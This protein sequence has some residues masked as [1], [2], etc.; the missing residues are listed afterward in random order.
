M[1]DG[2]GDLN[3]DFKDRTV[4]V[5]GASRGLGAAAARAFAAA[6]A[7][8]FASARN[9]D[10]LAELAKQAAAAGGDIRPLPASVTSTEEVEA[11]AAAIAED[12]GGIDILVANAGISPSF[13]RP[14]TLGD[15]DWHAIVD[16]NLTGVFR[17]CRAAATRMPTGA[18]IVNVSSI[19]S[20]V[21]LGRL[22]AYCASKAGLEGLTRSLALEW[23]GK[24]IRVNAV[25]PGYI[26]T[27]MTSGLR[28]HE[29]WSK[30]F[31]GLIP[32]ERFAQPEEI[33]DPILF[34]AS[35]GARYIT[36]A[37]LFVDGG[38]TAK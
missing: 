34:L 14:E 11:A 5:T 4:W 15:E 3:P 6:G 13:V 16:T 38:W 29:Y 1:A 7:T 32:M 9:A 20:K 17:S 10:R 2:T 22:S 23:A 37:T 12:R 18:S 33:V 25:A 26:E 21:G 8:V 30:F 31:L 19:H 24:G 35:S 36:G 27:D 28:D